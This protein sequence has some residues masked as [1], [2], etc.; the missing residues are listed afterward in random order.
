[1]NSPDKKANGGET[2]PED[3]ADLDAALQEFEQDTSTPVPKPVAVADSTKEF[4]EVV[5]YVREERLQKQNEMIEKAIGGAVDALL[6]DEVLKDF[7][8]DLTEGFLHKRYVSDPEF[9][10]AFDEHHQHPRVWKGALDKARNAF[11]E[12]V[13][14]LLGDELR[15]DIENAAATVRGRSETRAPA[16]GPSPQ[17]MLNMSDQDFKTYKRGLASQS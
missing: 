11:Q 14:P 17:D 10:K 3:D 15:K 5:E 13:R 8:R 6:D 9:K 1:M 16:D 12:K 7:D 2:L 4:S